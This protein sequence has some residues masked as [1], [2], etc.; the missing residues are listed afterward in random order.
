[1]IS[2]MPMINVLFGKSKKVYIKPSYEEIDSVKDYAETYLNYLVTTTTEAD[3]PQ[4]ALLYI[5]I[6]IISMFL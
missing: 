6:L 4:R 1:M 5:I 3:G 2:L